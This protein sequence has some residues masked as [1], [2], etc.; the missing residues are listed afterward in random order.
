M[1]APAFA[2]HDVRFT[3]GDS[4]CAAWLKLTPVLARDLLAMVRGANPAMI[5]LAAA[6]GSPA[7]MTAPDALP[8]YPHPVLRQHHRQRHP[9]RPDP[10]IRTD[11]TPG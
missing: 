4:T 7:L 6:P 5:P 11:R 2:R 8:G 10:P 3:S 1:T 9:S